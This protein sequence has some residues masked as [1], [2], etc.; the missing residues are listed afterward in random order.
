[1]QSTSPP[2]CPCQGAYHGGAVCRETVRHGTH[3]VN[4]HPRRPKFR[5][6]DFEVNDSPDPERA[7]GPAHV[8]QAED[9][10]RRVGCRA[11]TPGRDGESS[12]ACITLPSGGMRT[13]VGSTSALR[14]HGEPRIPLSAVVPPGQWTM[15][16]DRMPGHAC[17]TYAALARASVPEHG[18][19]YG[20][21]APG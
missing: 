20:A 11:A 18:M 19:A 12:T 10:R 6:D 2:G 5:G 7:K 14:R 3:R 9:P 15:R 16:N 13:L 1:M 8:G 4:G 21:R 17:G